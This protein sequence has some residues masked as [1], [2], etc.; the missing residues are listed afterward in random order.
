MQK[1]LR[2]VRAG[3]RVIY[4]PGNHDEWLRDYL[5]LHFGGVEIVE[6]AVH[7]T[8]DGRRLLV[9][10]GDCFDAIVK[11]AR[12]L[13]ML[14]DNVY[15]LALW[16]NNHFNRVRRALGY[17][18]WSLS[19]FL[20]LKVK[21][22]VMYIGSFAEALCAEARARDLDGVVCG[23]IHHAEIRPL[24]GVLY[25]NDGDWVESCTAMVEHFDGRLEIV[26]WAEE[27]RLYDAPAPVPVKE[28]VPVET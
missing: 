27:R 23:H 7:V 11:H 22:A 25:C 21:N 26:H 6:E 28:L 17:D 14:G 3:T 24:G 18:Y 13:A 12:W 8:V 9:I 20:K 4:I 10:H 1:L 5:N 19:A 16:V 15:M 2:K